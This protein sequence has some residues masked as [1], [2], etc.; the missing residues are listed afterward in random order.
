MI[1]TIGGQK[2]GSGKTTI[3]TNLAIYLASQNHDVLLVDA[4]D[5]ESASDFTLMRDDRTQGNSGYECVK[6]TGKTIL[7]Q[8]P[9]LSNRY[10]DIVIDAGG[11]DTE[12]QRAAMVVSNIF[13]VPFVPRSFDIWTLETVE[14]LVQEARVP[15]PNLKAFVFINRADPRSA[16]NEESAE[17]LQQ[18][19]VLSFLDTP[20]V[21]RKAFA[22]A[23]ANGMGIIEMKQVDEKA[24]YEFNLLIKAIQKEVEFAL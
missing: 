2:G 13:L 6:L 16:E 17:K 11:R 15:N 24:V 9:K 4:D 21:A 19:Q 1:Y 18:S 12:S 3:A 8:I 22:T 10:Q 5:Q 20:I 7:T 14:F 23:A